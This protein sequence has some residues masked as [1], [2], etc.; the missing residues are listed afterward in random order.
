[1]LSS[2]PPG[3]SSASETGC[4]HKD[5]LSDWSLAPADEHV[6]GGGILP[7]R[8]DDRKRGMKGRGGRGRGGK[9]RRG[10]GTTTS[11][12]GPNKVSFNTDTRFMPK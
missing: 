5:E 1:M 4:E 6:S 11:S 10:R 9:G 2:A 3:P 7:R 12:Y 8:Q